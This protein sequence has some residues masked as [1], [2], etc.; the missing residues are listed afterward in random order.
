VKLL[1]R[2]GVEV[3][4]A[5]LDERIAGLAGEKFVQIHEWNR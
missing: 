1:D 2:H 4:P 3:L 5:K